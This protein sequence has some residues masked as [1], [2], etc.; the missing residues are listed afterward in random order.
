MID[1]AP[2]TALGDLALARPAAVPM[3][4]RLQLDYCCGGRRSL[5][6]ACS[7]QG[8]DPHTVIAMIE[9]LDADG[10]TGGDP[11]DVARASVAEL[12]DHIVKA[13]HAQ[14]RQELPRI[15]ELLETVV[16]VHGAQRTELVDVQRTFSSMRDELEEH[17]D[18]E[19]EQ[20]FPVCRAIEAGEAPAQLNRDV[21]AMCTDTHELTGEVLSALRELCGGYDPKLALCGTHRALLEALHRLE[22]DLH[23]H[24]HEENNLLFPR[25]REL[26]DAP[27]PG[28]P[29]P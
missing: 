14:T 11:H 1:I 9:A 26:A 5:E 25:V 24:V 12:C 8:L 19:E 18:L 6:E 10:A 4:E 16:R 21:L 3:L 29:A 27:H 13:H 15:A 28:R 2:T 22:L 20:L 23:Q 7:Q 17:F